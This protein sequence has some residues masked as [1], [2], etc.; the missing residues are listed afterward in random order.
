Q[1]AT[2]AL[3]KGLAGAEGA[4]DK[5]GYIGWRELHAADIDQVMPLYESLFGWTPDRTYDMGEMGLYHVFNSGE[6]QQGGAMSSPSMPH[7]NWMYYFTVGDIDAAT[8]RV[9]GAGGKVLMGPHP[10]PGGGWI[11]QGQDRQG[12]MFALLGTKAA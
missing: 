1:G 9:N 12:G 6:G 3:Y 4:M 2:F 5:P 8:D 7:P 10:V 11:L